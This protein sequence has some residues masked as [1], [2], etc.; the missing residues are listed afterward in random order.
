MSTP[1][2]SALRRIRQ[3][4]GISEDDLRTLAPFGTDSPEH[5]VGFTTDARG[6]MSYKERLH[7][8]DVQEGWKRGKTEF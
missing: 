1:F 3:V 2:D 6:E 4:L 7:A 5:Y 8:E